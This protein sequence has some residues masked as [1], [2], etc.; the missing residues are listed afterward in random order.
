MDED[1]RGPFQSHIL[2]QAVENGEIEDHDL[3]AARRWPRL[4]PERIPGVIFA[5][6][7]VSK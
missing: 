6:T 3:A 4:L 5:R 7:K 1:E 2:G